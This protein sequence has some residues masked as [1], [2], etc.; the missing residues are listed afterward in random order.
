RGFH[1]TGVQTCALPILAERVEALLPGTR[2]WVT[3]FHKF[4]A[5]LLRQYADVVGLSG[6]YTI[7]DTTD[8]QNALRHV[9]RELDFDPVSMSPRSEAR[10][11]GKWGRSRGA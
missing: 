3:T 8:Q 6:N 1:V 10:R 5:R 11:V 7:L 9:M 4:C 2:V